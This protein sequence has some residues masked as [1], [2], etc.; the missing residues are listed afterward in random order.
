M[1]SNGLVS[2]YSIYFYLLQKYYGLHFFQLKKYL[3]TSLMC[4][5]LKNSETRDISQK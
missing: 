5:F 4:D 3:V 1:F 2:L